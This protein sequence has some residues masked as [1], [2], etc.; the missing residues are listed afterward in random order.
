MKI[1]YVGKNYNIS[2][3]LKKITVKK[4]KKLKKYFDDDTVAKFI[5][6]LTNN[7][8]KTELVVIFGVNQLRAEAESDN[9][10]RNLDIVIPKIQ[11]Q[12]RKTKTVWRQRITGRKNEKVAPAEKPLILDEEPP[13]PEV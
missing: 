10:Y 5:I 13:K 12:M 7:T 9:P 6:T 8:Y 1:E 2:E 11:G 4:S 3:Q